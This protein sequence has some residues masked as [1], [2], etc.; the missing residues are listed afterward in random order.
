M[1]RAAELAILAVLGIALGVLWL[2]YSGFNG[3]REGIEAMIAGM[4]ERPFVYR[5]LA[6]LLVRSIIAITGGGI[7]A[8][9]VELV[10]LS[11]V[12]WLW[13]LRWLAASV[14]P[15]SA[16]VATVL[17][18]G[19]VGLLFVSGGYLYDPLT[20][21]LFTFALALLARRHWAAF[22]VLFPW[23]VLCRET[24]ALLTLVYAVWAWPR[25]SR[26]RFAADLAYQL[27]VFAAVKL[28]LA[29]R[30]AGNP[31]ATVEFHPAEQVAFL[32]AY[33]LP[34]VL[35]LSVYGAGLAAALWRWNDQSAF[36][37]AAAVIL[38]AMFGAY[39][40]LGFPGELRI[41]LEAYPVLF[42]LVWH[43]V[44]SRAA[45]PTVA[46]LARWRERRR[47]V[48]PGTAMLPGSQ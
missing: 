19:P 47:Q 5:Q 32:L 17:A 30:F 31:G 25:V 41:F 7:L 23:L 38:P 40:L 2:H 35:A 39:W 16:M 10:L 24:S 20:L 28:W 1:K 22:C 15:G 43:T 3:P 48:S 12:G 21:A 8:A 27:I 14:T 11:F 42:L 6:A 18:V 45:L 13:A 26:R 4:A 44:W 37:R 46:T 9:S 36:L 34:N 33:P 29:V